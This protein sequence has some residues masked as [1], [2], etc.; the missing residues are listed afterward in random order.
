LIEGNSGLSSISD[1]PLPGDGFCVLLSNSIGPA[2]IRLKV[3]ES[4]LLRLHEA[5]ET[6]Q[7]LLSKPSVSLAQI[8][9]QHHLSTKMKIGLAYTLARSVWQYYNSDWMGSGW[10]C[11]TI[12]F[13]LE[14]SMNPMHSCFHASKP[15]FTVRFQSTAQSLPERY[16]L[17][18][19]IH[20]YPRMLAL[21]ILLID[22]ARASYEEGSPTTSQTQ[23]QKANTDYMRG[24]YVCERDQSWPDLGTAD[25]ARLRLRTVYKAATQS[26]FDINVFK[27]VSSSSIPTDESDEAEE[28]RKI[29]YEK[30][31]SP[32]E[33]IIDE[34]GWTDT[35]G[36]VEAIK[37]DDTVLLESASSIRTRSAL[38]TQ[39][40]ARSSAQQRT[41]RH[42]SQ[43]REQHS[44]VHHKASLFDDEMP[45]DGHTPGQ[46]VYAIPI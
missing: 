16:D 4:S 26:C 43:S 29:L 3:L 14:N 1:E 33:D 12:H 30:V 35:L 39:E 10:N 27:N 25:A 19:I 24:R 40:R 13:M 15:C 23:Q 38:Y 42:S 45:M 21:G 20:K 31:V 28:H 36:H 46:C 9:Q 32:L 22:L 17:P 11:D 18:M 34:M 2:K 41:S 44:P 7:F 37:F 5:A 6:D 8:L